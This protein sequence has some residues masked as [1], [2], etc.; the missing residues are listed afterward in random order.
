MRTLIICCL[1]LLACVFLPAASAAEVND[2]GAIRAGFARTEI[3]CPVGIPLIGSWGKPSETVL[4][5]LYAR[6]MVLTDGRTTL[7]VL[8]TDLLYA[9]L[10]E[11]AAPVRT[12]VKERCGI[13][14]QNVLICATH[15]HSGPEIF[16]RSKIP[17]EN[18]LDASKI[19]QAYLHALVDK[20]ADC[21]CAARADMRPAGIGF[22]RGKLPEVVFNRRPIGPD[23]KAKMTLSVTPE[24]AA[25]RV[26]RTDP[27]GHT[28]TSFTRLEQES[29]LQFGP[30][31]PDLCVLRVED[32]AGAVMGTIINFGCHPVCV[33]P[34]AATAISADYP[35]DAA[36][37]VEQIEGGTCL[38]TLAPAGDLVPYQRGLP[39]HEKIGKAIGAEALKSLQFV[40]TTGN[41]PLAALTKQIELPL[42]ETVTLETAGCIRTEIQVLR[43]GDI[44]LVGLPGEILVEIG[45]EI[46]SKAGLDK[47]VL[48]SLAN[49]AVGYV[50][51]AAAYDQGGYEP[52]SGT[53]LAKGSAEILIA[54]ALDLLARMKSR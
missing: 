33:Y 21:V 34:S 3:T 49:D 35:G 31:D 43:I 50:C 53:L 18:R 10:E 52:G 14:E 48:V 46:K 8:S 28:C 17:A 36:A 6:A 25:T 2:G 51:P 13:P 9:P 23:G 41:A 20:L 26:T 15:T 5:P 24:V 42:K 12:L 16:T 37:L 22:G 38:F 27:E 11:L 40:Q 39:A 4:D 7:A 32:T 45:L 54:E 30:V 29:G 19:D 44:Y 47:L 1:A